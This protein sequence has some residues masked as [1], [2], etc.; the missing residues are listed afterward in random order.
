MIIESVI[1]LVVIG[2]VAFLF[3]KSSK[4]EASLTDINQD[5]KTDIKDAVVVLNKVVDAAEAAVEKVTEKVVDVVDVNND[6]K[7]DKKDAEAVVENVKKKVEAK[8]KKTK[9]T[10]VEVQPEP[11]A[12]PKRARNNGKLVADNPATPDINEAWEGGKAPEKKPK[13]P[14][15]PKMTVAK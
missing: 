11:T 4:D 13:K 5:G 2:A 6:G 1:G 10:K 8:V 7:V 14:K 9:T 15:K 3:W 12:A